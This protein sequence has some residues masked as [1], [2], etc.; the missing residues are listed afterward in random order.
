MNGPNSQAQSLERLNRFIQTQPA[1]AAAAAFKDGRDLLKDG[2]WAKAEAQFNRFIAEF[3]KD[4]EVAAALY[5]VAFSLKQ[6]GKFSNTDAT[7][8]R[9]IEQYPSSPWITD[10]R[11]MR[12]EIAPRLNNQ[13][14]IDQGVG[15]TND[16]VRIAALQSLFE[17]RPERA[18]TLAADL[19]KSG[20]GA[21]RLVK[22]S[23]LTLLAD[24][25]SREAVPLLA[26]VARND[27]DTRL[28]KK[29]IEALG[30]IDDNSALEP[31]KALALQTTDLSIARAALEAAGDHESAARSLFLEV[32]RSNAS[33]E[34]RADAIEQLGDLDEDP[35]IV[36][37]LL[38]LLSAEK[39]PRLQEA[40]IET[41][42]DIELPQAEIALTSVARSA[43]TVE[44]RLMVVEALNDREGEGAIE[45]L[46]QLY[47]AEKDERVKE[48]IIEAFGD[49]EEKTALRKLIDIAR[50][51]PSLKLRKRAIS[52]L[53]GNDDPEVTKFL[54]EML[55]KP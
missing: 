52:E 9:L 48:E 40:L 1:S 51:D 55:K 37:D 42:A 4:R 46:I 36:D 5:Y 50:R 12:V 7:L 43:P 54:E 34:L 39:H 33:V 53:A 8:T 6:Q 28:R 17:S 10:A 15:A 27:S 41:L 14:V 23:A 16:E 45:S 11:A 22:E 3:P 21:S 20:S 30:E 44:V 18:L 25:E 31:L 2:E 29:A 47:D 19:L 49:S 35:G 26:E 32:A 38:K 13:Q 24:S